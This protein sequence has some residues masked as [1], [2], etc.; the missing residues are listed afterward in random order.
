M[1]HGEIQIHKFTECTRGIRSDSDPNFWPFYETP[2][3]EFRARA[4]AVNV[5]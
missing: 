5:T 2:G 3:Y 4:T 1:Y